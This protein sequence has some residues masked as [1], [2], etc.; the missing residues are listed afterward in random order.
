MDNINKIINF[1]GKNMD[2]EY[3]MHNLSKLLVI[4][5]ATFHRVIKRIEDIIQI[6]E[7]G[8]S[9]IV[10]LNQNNPI[11][12]S[13]LAVASDEEKKEFLEN[14]PI[15]KRITNELDTNDVVIL[16]GSYAKGTKT[17]KSDIDLL[18]INK[19]GKKSLAFSK[20][21][22]IYKKQINPIFITKREF[23]EMLRSDEENVGK[24]ALN[25]HITLNNP[26]K[27]WGLVLD[28]F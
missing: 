5:Y 15:L 7:I 14:E 18:I 10:K 24:Q 6:K 9:K 13:K 8:K 16:F 19:D 17:Q 25:N 2:K 12:K 27:F 26:E 11:I 21:E 3:T 28:E 22:L 20:Y 1:L 23:K 4:P